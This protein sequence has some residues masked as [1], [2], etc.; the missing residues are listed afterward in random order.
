MVPSAAG[1]TAMVAVAVVLVSVM[2]SVVDCAGDVAAP[3]QPGSSMM[4]AAVALVIII[5]EMNGAKPPLTLKS[6]VP[7]PGLIVPGVQLVPTPTTPTAYGAMAAVAAPGFAAS[8]DTDRVM[9][10]VGVELTTNAML[11]VA[12]AAPL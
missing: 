6:C 11:V 9:V 10:C 7:L 3:Y 2:V 12:T 5:C 8:V 1:V 4:V